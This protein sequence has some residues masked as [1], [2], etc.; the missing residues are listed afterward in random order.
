[1]YTCLCVV[2][3][4]CP[5][6]F[7][8]LYYDLVLIFWCWFD[9]IRRSVGVFTRVYVARVSF[10]PL[11][12][13]CVFFAFCC[14]FV[15]FLW[16]LLLFDVLYCILLQW[17]AVCGSSRCVFCSLLCFCVSFSLCIFWVSVVYFSVI[18]CFLLL[19]LYFIMSLTWLQCVDR[20]CY[21]S[22]SH[23]LDSPFPRL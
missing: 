1:M 16:F 20:A 15:V 4:S 18:L 23:V 13:Q 22:L 14:P 21:S 9:C 10:L 11:C 3:F 8:L 19:Y 6:C 7:F 2:D 5:A 17:M 12:A